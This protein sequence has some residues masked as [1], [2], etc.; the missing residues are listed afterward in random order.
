MST[1]TA[2]LDPATAYNTL[3]TEVHRPVYFAKLAE[4]GVVP[5]SEAEAE[6]LFKIGY[7]LLQLE[8]N[9]LVKQAAGQ[10]AF[11]SDVAGELD[12]VLGVQPE[13]QDHALKQA[14]QHFIG[15]EDLLR[16]ALVLQAAR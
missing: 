5:R 15:N 2:A 11:L 16:A 12:R 7:Q 4:Y 3:C 6:T 9:E 14:A 8:Q 1:E 10:G 13:I